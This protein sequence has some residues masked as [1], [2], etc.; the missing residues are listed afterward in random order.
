MSKKANPTVIGVFIVTG[1]VLLVTGLIVFSAGNLFS[2]KHTYIAYFE[3]SMKGMNKGAPVQIKGVPIGSVLDIYIHH[4]QRDEDRAMA[5]VFEVD[6][7]L[8]QDKTDRMMRLDDP[9]Q[10]QHLI[11]KGLRARLD[12]AS[13]VT[14]VLMVQLD[15]LK[16]PPPPVYHQV[17]KQYR[18][19]P[20]APTD[21]QMLLQNLARLDIQGITDKLNSILDRVD[22]S[23]SQLNVASINAGLTNVLDSIDRTIGSAEFTNSIAS[24]HRT[25]DDF[26]SLARKLEGRVDPL[27]GGVTNTLAEVN[28]AV[29]ELRNAIHGLSTMVAPDSPLQ[30]ELNTALQQVG[31]AARSLSELAEFLKRNPN[32]LI[33]GRNPPQEK[34]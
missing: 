18:E 7:K 32:A 14:G 24:L 8:L 16:D 26:G 31:G 1:V 19:I 30:S 6:E 22:T 9:K 21:I 15:F 3:G 29:T 12:A 10:L 13:I 4:N 11:D 25:L 20:T 23:L 2:K 27:A 5:V 17:R 28:A 34:P 33:T